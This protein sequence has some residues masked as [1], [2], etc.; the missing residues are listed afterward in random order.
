MKNIEAKVGAFVVISAVVLGVSVY[1]VSKA[2]LSGKQVPYRTYLRY[3]GGL[4]SGT[5]VLFG[6]ITVG[7]VAAVQPDPEDPTRI[8]IDLDV[9]PGTPIN[10]K[11]LA[12]LGSVS[13]M[14]SPVVS[15]ST[16][17]RDAPR[18]PAGAVIPSQETI[19]MDDMERKVAA[20]A[21]S[22]Q[23]TLTSVRTDLNNL[24]GDGR[25]LLANLNNV[26][27]TPNQKHI[28]GILRN[29]D[30]MVAQLSPKMGPTVDNVNRT[31][32][33]AN[34]TITAIRQPAQ[35]DL[36]EARKMLVQTQALLGNVQ[37]LIQTNNQ[38]ITY[39]LEN[40][41]MATDNLND[42]TESVK[43]QPW[44]LIRIKQPKDRKVPK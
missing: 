23:I 5:G 13:L 12:K 28:S 24:T 18:L 20:L 22:A 1:Y 42:L 31:V 19:S 37:S 9:K 38:N 14:S 40:I 4:E 41:R 6:G 34:E 39:T 17:S 15:I 30:G 21:D 43:E 26:T 36:E 2:A 3:A 27:G 10:A 25:H 33:N 16:G 8:E 35:V 11:S 29:A 44:S 7:K 32:S